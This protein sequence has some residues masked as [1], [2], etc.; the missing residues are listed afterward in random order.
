MDVSN[1]RR[2]ICS[3]STVGHFSLFPIQFLNVGNALLLLLLFLLYPPPPSPLL[4]PL[5]DVS[6]G[7]TFSVQC[8]SPPSETI[9]KT[10]YPVVPSYGHTG[11]KMTL[12]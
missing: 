2:G 12:K 8:R 11:T 10:N 3:L 1:Y 4:L 9:A 5:E 6:F 7:F